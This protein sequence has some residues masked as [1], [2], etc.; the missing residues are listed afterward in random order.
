MARWTLWPKHRILGHFHNITPAVCRH[1]NYSLV[2]L[3]FQLFRTSCRASAICWFCGKQLVKRQA[4]F[5]FPKCT[6]ATS[7]FAGPRWWS[8]RSET[9]DWLWHL[10]TLWVVP[11]LRSNGGWAVAMVDSVFLAARQ[12]RSDPLV[13]WAPCLSDVE[14]Y[15]FANITPL[16]TCGPRIVILT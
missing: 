9:Q 10:C 5:I 11:L 8:V 7:G 4:R 14:S 16:V 15:V 3:R 2:G 13:I 1:S 6:S 12:S